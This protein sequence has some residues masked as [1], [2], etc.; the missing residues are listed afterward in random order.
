MAA[1]ATKLR[2]R[3]TKRF[4]AMLES[5]PADVQRQAQ[6][7]YRQFK[8]DPAHGSLH[9]KRLDETEPP[10]YGV[11]VGCTIVQWA[12]CNVTPS[13]GIGLGATNHSTKRLAW[14]IMPMRFGAD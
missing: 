1:L 12:T 5:L 13:R 8:E 14:T 11:R 4:R 2:S 7:A 10:R 3:R 9:F 6:A